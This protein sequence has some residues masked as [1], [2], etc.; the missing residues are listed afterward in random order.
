LIAVSASLKNTARSTTGDLSEVPEKQDYGWGQINELA[1]NIRR[2]FKGSSQETS[3]V[4]QE[5]MAVSTELKKVADIWKS[6]RA[7]PA[8]SYDNADI[9]IIRA[10]WYNSYNY[11]A[12]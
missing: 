8:I 9:A 4:A 3:A 10:I 5:L 1:E 12:R 11:R 6:R 2:M 7:D